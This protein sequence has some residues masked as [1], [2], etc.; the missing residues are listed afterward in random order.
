MKQDQEWCW[1]LWIVVVREHDFDGTKSSHENGYSPK[2][3]A[4]ASRTQDEEINE[5]FHRIVKKLRYISLHVVE[6]FHWDSQ[7]CRFFLWV[8]VVSAWEIIEKTQ[9]GRILN[10]ILNLGPYKL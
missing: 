5:E 1:D 9:K 8:E 7:S 6:T 10:R 2:N 4:E 3:A